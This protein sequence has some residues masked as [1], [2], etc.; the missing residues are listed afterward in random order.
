MEA[1][2]QLKRHWHLPIIIL[3]MTTRQLQ[4][5]NG[6]VTLLFGSFNVKSTV[7]GTT[8]YSTAYSC[9]NQSCTYGAG[10]LCNP[11]WH[12]PR[13]CSTEAEWSTGADGCPNL[14]KHGFNIQRT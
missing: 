7:V 2:Q 6:I 13:Y 4:R 3:M 9:L 1:T 10:Y 11:P 8:T 14:F 12:S 5:Y